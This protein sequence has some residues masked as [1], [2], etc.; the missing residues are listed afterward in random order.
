MEIFP[1][2][3]REVLTLK[4]WLCSTLAVILIYGALFSGIATAE[5][6]TGSKIT[7]STV[8]MDSVDNWAQDS[9]NRWSQRGILTGLSDGKFHPDQ[10]ISRAEWAAII[11]RIFQFQNEKNVAYTDV[12][13]E[14]WFSKDVRIAAAASYMKGYNDGTFRPNEKITRQEAAVTIANLLS[15]KGDNQGAVFQDRSKIAS[16]ASQAIAANSNAKI[17]RGYGDGTF[18]PLK[19]LTRA[20]A[21]SLL[22]R[23]FDHFGTWYG[24]AGT[25]GPSEGV[26]KKEGSVVISRPGITLNNLDISGDLII[27]KGVGDGDVYLRN[28]TVHGKTYVYGGGE[29]SVHLE[30]VVMLTVIVNK[31]DGTVRLVATGNSLIQEV[32]L[33]TGTTLEVQGNAAI[34]RV[35]MVNELPVNSRVVLSGQFNTVN[36]EAKSILVQIPQGTVQNLNIGHDAADTKV[37]TTKEASILSLIL[38]AAASILGLGAIENATINSAGVTLDQTPQK[39]TIGQDV[40]HDVIVH[41]GDQDKTADSLIQPPAVPSS[42]G[43]SSGTGNGGNT[44]GNNGDLFDPYDGGNYYFFGLNSDV[45]SVTE[46]VYVTSPRDGVAYIMINSVNSKDP[47]M[48]D[49]AV[50][51]G[52]AKKVPVKAGVRTQLDKSGFNF[53]LGT[54]IIIVDNQGKF[55]YIRYIRVL[56]DDTVP[57]TQ[58]IF[59]MPSTNTRENFEITFNRDLRLVDGKDLRASVTL[60]TYS[61]PDFAPLTSEDNIYIYRNTIVIKPANPFLGKQIS[62]KLAAGTV[63]TLDG[64]YQNQEFTSQPMNSLTHI[65][66]I[67]PVQSNNYSATMKIGSIFKFKV[68]QA[69]TVYFVSSSVISSRDAI[70]AEV[71]A[72]RGFAYNIDDSQVDQAFEV[73]TAGLQ[74]G[75]YYLLTQNGHLISVNLLP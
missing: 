32:T 15:L 8:F 57:L 75:E 28:V 56:D 64:G 60:S 65:Q 42:S 38:N 18:Q 52:V 40:P 26:E 73:N 66:I 54:K 59:G 48:L 9:I 72:G 43:G 67:D 21:V 51:A 50:E 44:G 62:F 70:L 12:I 5:T 49:A 11:N 47:V 31:T 3:S 45:F 34:D 2:Y 74:E 20:E 53:D 36:I 39:M 19:E 35:S 10:K 1:K 13:N 29:H 68:S 46:A 4:K 33:Q 24:E 7:K 22:D 41:V 69:D 25:F 14:E 17:I 63:E 61:N 71:A 23:A 55:S 6:G 58:K 16:W 30:N 27:G 37:E